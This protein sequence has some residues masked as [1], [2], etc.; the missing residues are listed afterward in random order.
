MTAT[1]L[2][3]PYSL[4]LIKPLTVG[5]KEAPAILQ[6]IL[7]NCPVVLR[8]FREWDICASTWRALY[9]NND[10]A[11]ANILT[12]L[13]G[14]GRKGWVCLFTHVDR[15]SDPYPTLFSLCVGDGLFDTGKKSIRDVWKTKTSTPHRSDTVI[16]I[17]DPN[18]VK[19]EADLLLHN[20]KEEQL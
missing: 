6:Y 10:L 2:I 15:V 14:I 3:P 9:S 7:D 13:P 4:I 18:R 5:R 20:F 8:Q 11:D 19:L 17:S 1:S 16:H 12:S